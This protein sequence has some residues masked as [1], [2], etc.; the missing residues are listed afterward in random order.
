MPTV[1]ASTDVDAP[2]ARVW[3]VL[4]DPNGYPDLVV[5]TERVLDTSDVPI[6]QGTV[7]REYGGVRPFRGRST[8]TVTEF[9]PFD[10]QR[11][12]GKESTMSYD[13]AMSFDDLGD[14][15]TRL[16]L[17]LE[18][19]PAWYLAVMNMLVWPTLMRARTQAAMDQT[20]DNIRRVA[21]AG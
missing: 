19:I 9:R 8:W 13:L 1:V 18:I 4:E 14:G 5:A 6:Q 15:R 11:H 16:V 3:E 17:V 7:Y 20:V 21:E 10:F 12:L 2:P